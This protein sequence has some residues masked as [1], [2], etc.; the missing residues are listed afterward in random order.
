MVF[1]KDQSIS[2]HTKTAVANSGNKLDIVFRKMARSIVDKH[3]IIA[4]AMI[5]I[6]SKFHLRKYIKSIT[7]KR[8]EL[9][10]KKKLTSSI[11]HTISSSAI[12][13]VKDAFS[14]FSIDKMKFQ[15]YPTTIGFYKKTLRMFFHNKTSETIKFNLQ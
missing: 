3:E 7:E 9:G 2:A 13:F 15:T 11:W 5:F 14:V 8:A 12:K 1:Y 10:V 4:R 6:K